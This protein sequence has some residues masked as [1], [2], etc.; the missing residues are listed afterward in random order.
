MLESFSEDT[1]GQGL[2]AGEGF[3]PTLAIAHDARQA[4]DFGEPPAVSLAFEL[5]REGHAGNVPSSCLAN[6]AQDSP[7][8]RGVQS[9]PVRIEEVGVSPKKVARKSTAT[10]AQ[11][12]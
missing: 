2:D 7:T 4:L 10:K 6:K 3:V 9:C 1:Q 12:W 5:D 8:R 11:G